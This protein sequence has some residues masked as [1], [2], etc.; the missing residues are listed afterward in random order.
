V[1]GSEGLPQPTAAGSPGS[2]RRM[3]PRDGRPI[4]GWIF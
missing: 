4:F 3:P 2:G 1:S